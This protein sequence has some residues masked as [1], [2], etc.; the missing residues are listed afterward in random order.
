MSQ[1][2]VMTGHPLVLAVSRLVAVCVMV[3]G[4]WRDGGMA[5][6]L[7]CWRL[8]RKGKALAQAYTLIES[9]DR[10]HQDMV[11]QLTTELRA[12][13]RAL[14]LA[15]MAFQATAPQEAPWPK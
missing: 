3:M 1:L 13:Q 6:V 14:H 15:H 2:P 8:H 11:S 9:E 4:L 10:L 12:H 7:A 5:R